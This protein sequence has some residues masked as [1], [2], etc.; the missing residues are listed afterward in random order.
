M[1]L[2]RLSEVKEALHQELKGQ[3]SWKMSFLM[4]R[5][6]LRTGINL[7]AIRPEQ[8][9]DTAVLARVVQTL[10]DMGYR[11]GRRENEVIR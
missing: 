6:A 8:E 9:Q 2:N 1:A 3:D 11:V 7:D 4:T 5:V 10:Q